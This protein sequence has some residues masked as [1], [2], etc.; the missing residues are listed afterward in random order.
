MPR[1]L[2]APLLRLFSRNWITLFGASLTTVSALVI[3][4]FLILGAMGYADSPYIALMAL[5]VLP[6]VFVF[7]LL[8][9]PLGAYIDKRQRRKAREAGEEEA[10][11]SYP[12]I[13]L[14]KDRVRRAAIGVSLLTVINLLIISMVSY[15]GVVYMDSSEFCGEVCHTV[16]EPEYVAYQNSPH[17]RVECVECHIGP[18]APWFVRSKLSGMGQVLAVTFNTYERPIP[19]PV[20][21]LRPS[22]DTCEQ[23]HWPA[24]FTGNHMRVMDRYMDDEANTH[25]QTVLLMHIGGGHR[26]DGEGIHSWHIDPDKRTVY[27]AADDQRQEIPWVQVTH[28][29]GTVV[30]YRADGSELTDEEIAAAPKR[31][32]DCI[33]CHNRPTHIYKLPAPAMDEALAEGRIS[34]DI[35]FIKRAGVQILQEV[36]DALAPVEQVA[37][38]LREYYREN[39]SDYFNANRQQLETAIREIQRIYSTNVFPEMN[40]T[41]GTYPD[42]IGHESFPGCFRCHDGAHT[43]A[44]GQTINQDCASCHNLLAWEE[45][46]PEILQQFGLN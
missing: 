5:L 32:M 18:G 7:G 20:E 22:Q 26:P 27:I 36:G 38:R 41:W 13:D 46:N 35:P 11:L 1:K 15:R 30:E 43:S 10:P 12:M 28:A 39:H 29:D 42:N 8:L 21:N 45:E 17:S 2:L 37:Q 40:V 4:G 16:M 23:C 3:I 9:I 14:N 24:R 19:T 33:D 25:T 34:Q 31:E 6:G 44:D